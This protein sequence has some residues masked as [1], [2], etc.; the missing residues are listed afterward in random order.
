MNGKQKKRMVTWSLYITQ[1]SAAL[2][3]QSES[4]LIS[5]CSHTYAIFSGCIPAE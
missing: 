1:L 2:T 4:V 5:G 3:A